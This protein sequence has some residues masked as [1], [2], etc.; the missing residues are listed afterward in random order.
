MALRPP[1]IPD[2]SGVGKNPRDRGS[3]AGATNLNADGR[4]MLTDG[5]P[6]QGAGA[7]GGSYAGVKAERTRAADRSVAS[8][9]RHTSKLAQWR[10]RAVTQLII[11]Q[12]RDIAAQ[13]SKAL[14][15]LRETGSVAN[16]WCAT[17]KISSMMVRFYRNRICA[18]RCTDGCRGGSRDC[19][20]RRV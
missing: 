18:D 11:R 15:R 9:S 14:P 3:D 1:T 4:E 7:N 13:Q 16:R 20:S 10:R 6:E 12:L 17:Y 2:L 8:A 19:L 5:N